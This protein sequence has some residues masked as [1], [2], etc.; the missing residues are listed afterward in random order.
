MTQMH[1]RG[2]LQ[3]N[4]EVKKKKSIYM[5]TKQLSVLHVILTIDHI[6]IC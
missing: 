6:F 1:V 3:W 2:E 4:N 5:P